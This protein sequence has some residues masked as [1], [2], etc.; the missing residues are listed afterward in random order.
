MLGPS[1]SFPFL[2]RYLENNHSTMHVLEKEKLLDASESVVRVNCAISLFLFA[3]PFAE[4]IFA[5]HTVGQLAYAFFLLVP[6]FFLVHATA[7]AVFFAC[8]YRK[9]KMASGDPL[10]TKQLRLLGIGLIP[11][12]IS[13]ILTVGWFTSPHGFPVRIPFIF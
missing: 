1:S 5:G 9:G 10:R 4:F 13:F 12:L 8:V 3:L 2:A 6:L 11:L 7:M